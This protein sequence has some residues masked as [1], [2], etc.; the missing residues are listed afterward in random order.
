[1]GPSIDI[2]LLN[3]LTLCVTLYNNY[4][5]LLK[6]IRTLIN[7]FLMESG[8]HMHCKLKYFLFYALE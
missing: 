5:A 4:P 6:T 8:Y 2:H 7:N 3:I 1:M